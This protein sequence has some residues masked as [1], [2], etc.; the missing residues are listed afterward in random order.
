LSSLTFITGT[1]AELLSETHNLLSSFSNI[2][3]I[4]NPK[5][6]PFIPLFHIPYLFHTKENM[7]IQALNA[8]ISLINENILL[9]QSQK[10]PIFLLL[11]FVLRNDISSS[12]HLHILH[13]SL[14]SLISPKDPIITAKVLK[15]TMEL[16]QDKEINKDTRLKAVGIRVLYKVWE[17]QR[18]CWRSLRFILSNWVNNRKLNNSQIVDT[19]S[20]RFEVEVAVLTTI[21]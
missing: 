18:R 2:F 5:S 6:I 15:V 10:F 7:R 19:K 17:R 21:R 3:R 8:I 13:H 1:L 11:L 20:E 4:D 16:I 12:I 9:A 14:P